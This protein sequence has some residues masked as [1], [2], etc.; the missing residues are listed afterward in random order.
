MANIAYSKP[1][2]YLFLCFNENSGKFS[3]RILEKS[4]TNGKYYAIIH[5]VPIRCSDYCGENAYRQRGRFNSNG[6]H[7]IIVELMFVG[8]HMYKNGNT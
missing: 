4:L 8:K 2:Y 1:A 5:N 3:E 6:L 7:S